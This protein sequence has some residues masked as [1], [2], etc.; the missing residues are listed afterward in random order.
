M[1]LFATAIGSVSSLFS[2]IASAFSVPAG[3]VAGPMSYTL[4]GNTERNIVANGNF[5]NTT[6]LTAGNGTISVANN[7]CTVT[8]NGTASSAYVTQTAN[9]KR[10][11]QKVFKRVYAR[12]T[13]SA[14]TQLRF[15]VG[16]ISE[17]IASPV[18]NQWY[19]IKNVNTMPNDNATMFVNVYHTYADA[20]TAN[21]KVMEVKQEICIEMGTDTSNPLYNLT[22][23]QMDTRFP[24]WF[25]GTQS[26]GDVTLT[27]V[28]VNLF[29]YTKTSGTGISIVAGGINA[30]RNYYYVDD[31]TKYKVIPNKT[32]SIKAY[33]NIIQTTATRGVTV[34][35]YDKGDNYITEHATN[36]SVASGYVTASGVTPS[37]ADYCKFRFAHGITSEAFNV[38]TTEIQFEYS[39]SPTVYQP[40]TSNS[41]TLLKIG[42]RVGDKAD[43]KDNYGNNVKRNSDEYTLLS[44][45]IT[46][47]DT[48]ISANND[49]VH[50]KLPIGAVVP[51]DTTARIVKWEYPETLVSN[52][53]NASYRGFWYPSSGSGGTI[54]LIVNK[55]TYADVAAAKTALVGKIINY[56]L[57]TSI[58]TQ[59][60]PKPIIAYQ[61]GMV[62]VVSSTGVLPLIEYRTQTS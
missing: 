6:G 18:Q 10:V 54:R 44:A 45:D 58:V 28:G 61:G 12:V 38:N 19:E 30:N 47:L 57:L 39:A 5:V 15:Q 32:Y 25:D 31:A 51:T 41:Q 50:I 60:T 9:A 33:Q 3:T 16:A 37:N 49:I 48:V 34:V 21:G 17:D 59:E 22:A 4:S 24:S 7:I 13:N 62:S 20:S 52:Y 55:G 56:Q 53:N 11:G 46:A 43:S 36:R 42:S 40:Y 2:T 23:S 26:V 1:C 8:G 14:C 35:F 29:D 27:S